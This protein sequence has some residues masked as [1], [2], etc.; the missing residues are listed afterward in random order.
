MVLERLACDMPEPRKCPSFDSYQKRF[1][2]THKEVD[3][4]PH[5]VLGLVFQ[6]GNAEKFSQSF[7]FKSLGPFFR[8]SQQGPCF[9]AV[10]E[11]GDVKRLGQLEPAC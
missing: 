4:A 10:E 2:R 8:V 9:T 7:R 11:N 3:L 5:P 6:V 1:L